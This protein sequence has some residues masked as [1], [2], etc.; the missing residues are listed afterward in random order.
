M[1]NA[2]QAAAKT[3]MAKVT[4]MNQPVLDLIK[5]RIEGAAN[6]GLCTV[7]VEV[8]GNVFDK[9]A[10][11]MISQA[12]IELGY[13]VGLSRQNQKMRAPFWLFKISW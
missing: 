9:A 7:D 2:Q 5:Q 4:T 13:R 10:A 3:A 6:A 11:D 1:L 8:E 12:M